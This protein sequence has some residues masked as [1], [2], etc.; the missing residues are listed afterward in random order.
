M[1]DSSS[2]IASITSIPNQILVGDDHRDRLQAMMAGSGLKLR[3]SMQKQLSDISLHTTD[4]EYDDDDETESFND[5]SEFIDG[6][7][8]GATPYAGF[9]G[10]ADNALNTS[11]QTNPREEDENEIDMEE[12]ARIMKYFEE[13]KIAKLQD[14]ERLREEDEALREF[15]IMKEEKEKDKSERAG[16]GKEK[17]TTVEVTP[18]IEL[19]LRSIEETYRSVA[20]G[21]VV[22][23]TCYGC[24][25]R[26]HAVEGVTMI[27]CGDCWLCMPPERNE[28]QER[29]FLATGSEVKGS[30]GLGVTDED[31]AKWLTSNQT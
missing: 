16:G 11:L 7:G 25:Q 3:S 27:I 21:K 23:A 10:T 9:A 17:A 1:S 12:Q 4:L 22:S 13:K 26:F 14:K 28:R 19:P 6:D 2:A 18:G 24:Q 20:T 15:K 29:E 5:L 31:I 30:V 8:N